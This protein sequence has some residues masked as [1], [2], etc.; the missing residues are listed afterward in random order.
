MGSSLQCR[1]RHLGHP[2]SIAAQTV[3]RC[4]CA[5][6]HRKRS[7]QSDTCGSQCSLPLC[8]S[9]FHCRG[10]IAC[11]FRIPRPSGPAG[12]ARPVLGSAHPAPRGRLCRDTGSR[13]SLPLPH[14]VV[15]T[16]HSCLRHGVQ[17]LACRIHRRKRRFA[18]ND[19]HASRRS[20]SSIPFTQ[21][22]W[23]PSAQRGRRKPAPDIWCCREESNLRP[24][25]YESVALPTELLQQSVEL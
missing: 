8:E 2:A 11:R 10:R 18:L 17:G 16:P 1:Q 4:R 3:P 24:T 13:S 14:G 19:R 15:A 5:S 20:S 7:E 23:T 12:R 22:S 21:S 25:D 9:P 6:R